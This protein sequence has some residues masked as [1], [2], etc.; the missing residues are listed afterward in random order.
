[1]I[2]NETIYLAREGARRFLAA[3][4]AGKPEEAWPLLDAGEPNVFTALVC[5]LKTAESGQESLRRLLR[6][7]SLK[8]GKAALVAWVTQH[9]YLPL[10]QG[11]QSA[12]DY[13]AARA[14]ILVAREGYP[15]LTDDLWGP[16][17]DIAERRGFSPEFLAAYP[18]A[19]R[20]RDRI[21]AVAKAHVALGPHMRR[22]INLWSLGGLY[23]GAVADKGTQPNGT[24]CI[25]VGRG[26]YHAAGAN[27]ITRQI[28]P[29]PGPQ[30]LRPRP[31]VCDVSGGTGVWHP[32]LSRA[33]VPASRWEQLARGPALLPAD[34]RVHDPVLIRHVGRLATSR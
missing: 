33:Y 3:V 18:G 1:M 14:F 17:L 34:D 24:T 19:S 20:R 8:G 9:G 10:G 16:A 11:G 25:L 28:L 31:K 27:M 21:L 30:G 12:E 29:K 23:G 6:P 32:E 22:Q 2:E 26:V 15:Q 13:D 4:N 5:C 7:A